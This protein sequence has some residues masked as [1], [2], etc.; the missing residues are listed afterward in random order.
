MSKY[1]K[2]EDGDTNSLNIKNNEWIKFACCDCGMVHSI[3]FKYEKDILYYTM[4]QDPR[5]SAQ[6]RRRHFGELH[7]GIGKW[8]LVGMGD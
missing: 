2:V 8:K 5:A 3:T 7:N 1:T 4:T 6:M